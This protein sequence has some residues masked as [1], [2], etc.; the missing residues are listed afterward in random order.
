MQEKV[1][2]TEYLLK[3]K[4]YNDQ[5]VPGSKYFMLHTKGKG[6]DSTKRSDSKTQIRNQLSMLIT[7]K[8]ARHSFPVRCGFPLTE[9]T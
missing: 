9:F 8:K 7:Q 5:M 4:F 1:T 3:Y 6:Q 2:D